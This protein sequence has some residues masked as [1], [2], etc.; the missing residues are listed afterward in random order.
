M[1]HAWKVRLAIVVLA[2][3][4][5]VTNTGGWLLSAGN[6][7][8]ASQAW[9]GVSGGGH[10]DD[11]D[12]DKDRKKKDN[13]KDFDHFACY[14]AAGHDLDDKEVKIINQFT[15]DDDGKRVKVAITLGELTLL[16]VP[17]K[18][19]HIIERQPKKK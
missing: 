13:N 17:T 11:D 18:K 16:C 19:I 8:F 7:T 3:T 4:A 15:T 1:K 14:T 12:D 10:G 5:L 9:A 2:V 6:G